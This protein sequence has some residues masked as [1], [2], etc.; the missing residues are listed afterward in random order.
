MIIFAN[1]FDRPP[2][3]FFDQMTKIIFV[4]RHAQSAGK[5]SG[6]RDYDRVL[7]R[8]GEVKA[9]AL[10]QKLK[11]G[12]YNID[13]ILSSDATRTRSTAELLN[14]TLDLSPEK[15]H[16]KPE[17]YDALMLEWMDQIHKLTGDVQSVILVG[18]NPSLSMLATSFHTTVVDL[19]P[20]ELIGFEFNVDSWQEIKNS[21]K[22]ILN[23][24]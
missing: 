19:A 22:E 11:L 17:L 16:F 7:T 8:E 3:H 4:L 20:C 5:Q 18:H 1:D 24:K 6:Q 12:N 9:S 13:L 14:E 21:G 2:T 10:G 15:I 23:I